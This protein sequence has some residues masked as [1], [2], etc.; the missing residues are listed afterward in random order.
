MIFFKHTGNLDNHCTQFSFG[1]LSCL[2]LLEDS[3]HPLEF[4]VIRLDLLCII[5]M[6]NGIIYVE[7]VNF[8]LGFCFHGGQLHTTLLTIFGG[9]VWNNAPCILILET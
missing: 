6:G 4:V 8:L 5:T 1:A 2:V 3:M 9:M 7:M